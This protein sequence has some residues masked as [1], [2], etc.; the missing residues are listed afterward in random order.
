MP[1]TPNQIINPEP[2]NAHSP[3]VFYE[4]DLIV[5]NRYRQVQAL[6]NAFWTRFRVEYLTT[7]QERTKS[8][9]KTR[10]FVV[11]DLVMLYDEMK[12]AH[13]G[14]YPLGII[15]ATEPS[16][17]DGQVRK[18]TLRTSKG[19]YKRPVNKICLLEAEEERENHLRY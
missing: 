18:V 6:V 19:T 1:I 13:R 10:N 12:V 9:T 11:G 17:A 7:L 14:N 3:G 15:V 2:P 8:L 4:K 16:D 5:R